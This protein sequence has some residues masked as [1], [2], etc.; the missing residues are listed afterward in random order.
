MV[1]SVGTDK[2]DTLIL[3]FVGQSRYFLLLVCSHH[4]PELVNKEGSKT[5]QRRV[6]FQKVFS[7]LNFITNVCCLLF[8]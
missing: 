3:S 2:H 8:V 5:E 6:L 4:V 7:S 1:D